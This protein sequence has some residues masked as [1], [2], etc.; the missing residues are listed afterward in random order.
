[1]YLSW[2]DNSSNETSFK[3]YRKKGSGSWTLIVTKGANAK[4]YTDKAASG[5]TSTTSYSYYIKACNSKGCSPVTNT[6]T[7]PYRPTGPGAVPYAADQIEVSW[8]DKSSN[9]SGFQ[10]YRKTGT[11]SSTGSWILAGTNASNITTF[12][13]SGLS[14][15]TTYA[16][17]I[18]AYKKSWAQPY[19]YGYSLWSSCVEATISME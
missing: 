3:I 11:C 7:V 10:I 5:N 19:A 15:G 12:I 2:S 17:K 13:D 8:T 9:E 1:M 16:Y 6:A 4:S 14:P 18:R